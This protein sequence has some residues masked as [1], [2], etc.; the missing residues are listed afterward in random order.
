M[1]KKL[2]ARK[3]NFGKLLLFA[4]ILCIF[5]TVNWLGHQF[6]VISQHQTKDTIN[7]IIV[8]TPMLAQGKLSATITKDS[9]WDDNDTWDSIV[10]GH[11]CKNGRWHIWINFQVSYYDP[12]NSDKSQPTIEVDANFDSIEEELYYYYLP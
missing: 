4:L 9:Y 11:L 8:V 12:N 1:L 7:N 6:F 3:I 2:F 5:L 10:L